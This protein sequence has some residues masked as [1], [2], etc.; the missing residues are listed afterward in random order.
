MTTDDDD[1]SSS[2]CSREPVTD[3]ELQERVV[4][5]L[6]ALG[7]ALRIPPYGT[8]AGEPIHYRLL[9]DRL[10]VAVHTLKV[11]LGNGLDRALPD[12]TATLRARVAEL[13][14]DVYRHAGENWAFHPARPQ[15][16]ATGHQLR[17]LVTDFLTALLDML[18][19]QGADDLPPHPWLL[20]DRVVAADIALTEVLAGNLDQSLTNEADHLRDQLAEFQKGT[21]PG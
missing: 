6:T 8:E 17:S 12:Q 1:N 7:E 16:Q 2:V 20:E 21:Y 3:E 4:D 19:A 9:A 15:V 10:E 14:T 18:D 13:S 11:T 5:Y